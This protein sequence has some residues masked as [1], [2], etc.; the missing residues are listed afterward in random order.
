MSFEPKR[1]VLGQMDSVWCA[2][3]ATK[4]GNHFDP[5]WWLDTGILF[6]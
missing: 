5:V 2:L 3:F 1:I 6:L 4:G